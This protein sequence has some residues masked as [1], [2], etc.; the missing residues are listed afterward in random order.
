M[1]ESLP[2]EAFSAESASAVG[3][4]HDSAGVL[5]R[6]AR[7]TLTGTAIDPEAWPTRAFLALASVPGQYRRH[8][9]VNLARLDRLFRSDRR[10][11]L[12]GNHALDIVDP[13]LLLATVFR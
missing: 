7:A 3:T 12:V 9:V 6:R 8:R 11:I 2:E 4:L 5:S 13:L 10:V 1:T